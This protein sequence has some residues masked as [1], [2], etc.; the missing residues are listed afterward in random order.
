MHKFLIT[1]KSGNP[2]TGPIMVTTSPRKTCPATCPFK[3]DLCYA[4][5][6]FLGGFIWNGLDTTPPKHSFGNGIRVYSFGELLKEI[7]ML[8]AGSIWR[9]NQAGDL[10]HE[11]DGIISR[12]HLD[13]IADAN[14]GRYGFTYTH[15]DP[16]IRQNY[17]A[18]LEAGIRG[19][20]INLSANSLEHA[21]HLADLAIASVSVVLPKYA[22]GTIYTPKGRAVFMCPAVTNKG[23]TCKKCQIC[24]RLHQAIVGLPEV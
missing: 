17:H 21:D 11:C 1:H 10:I 5:R 3:G 20:T 24:S 6:G 15:Y 23:V 14:V 22:T 19:F 9:H 7:R 12:F 4:E 2:V 18:I 13:A 16:Y 8:P